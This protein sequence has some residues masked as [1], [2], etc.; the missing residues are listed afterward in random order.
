MM[1]TKGNVRA[2][3]ELGRIVVPIEYRNQLDIKSGDLL[4]MELDGEGIVIK[5][6]TPSCIFCG[7]ENALTKHQGKTI[8]I[9]CIRDISKIPN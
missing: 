4:R 8:C 6:N 9:N 5:K 3:D 2:I 1:R 7:A